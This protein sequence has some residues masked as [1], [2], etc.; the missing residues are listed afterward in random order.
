MIKCSERSEIMEGVIS[1]ISELYQ[2]YIS[3]GLVISVISIFIFF[4]RKKYKYINTI[5]TEE[6]PIFDITDITPPQLI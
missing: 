5:I 3:Y 2:N 4:L 1:V 6:N